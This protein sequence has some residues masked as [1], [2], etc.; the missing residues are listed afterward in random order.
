MGRV[1]GPLRAGLRFV[2][3]MLMVSGALLVL[4]AVATLVWQ[5]PVS[6]AIA[7]AQQSDLE[8]RLGELGGGGDPAAAATRLA[9][10]A[11]PG[12][13]LGR[14]SMP[15]LERSF[16]MVGPARS[17]RRRSAARPPHALR[18]DV[19]R[20]G[21]EPRRASPRSS[22]RHLGDGPYAASSGL[23]T[24]CRGTSTLRRKDATNVPSCL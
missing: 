24:D 22:R 19:R 18:D 5:E 13:P 8:R 12:D 15:T 6:W 4:D 3:A 14:I 1:R 20:R 16:V 21:A 17:G 7:R 9:A 2:A 10:R 23:P 11:E